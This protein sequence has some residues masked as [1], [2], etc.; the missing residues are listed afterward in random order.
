MPTVIQEEA[1]IV[2]AFP[3]FSPAAIADL[4]QQ[5]RQA[6]YYWMTTGKIE[7]FRDNIGEPYV[8]R[9]ELVRF[10]REY[11]GRLVHD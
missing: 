3:V 9:A 5:S 7:F 4:L 11:L 6:V 8:L 1:L 2:P 10:V